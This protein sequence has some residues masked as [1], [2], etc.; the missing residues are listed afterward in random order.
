MFIRVFFHC[1]EL[2]TFLE[3]KTFQL[4]ISKFKNI[5]I[6]R[7]GAARARFQALHQEGF[8]GMSIGLGKC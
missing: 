6:M 8:P 7:Y 5:Y 3:Y 2:S 1:G 4:E